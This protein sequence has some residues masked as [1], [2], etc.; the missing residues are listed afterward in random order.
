MKKLIA[1]FIV[2]LSVFLVLAS[3]DRTLIYGSYIRENGDNSPLGTFTITLSNNGKYSYYEGP[4]SSHIG[5]GEYTVDG[6]RIILVD[7]QIPGLHSTLTCTYVFEYSCGKL[8]FLADES[9]KFMYTNLPDGAVFE[10]K[11][12]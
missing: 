10:L 2:I 6:N 12:N 9:D 7:E 11:I 3:C 4:L 5:Y 8:I 1:L